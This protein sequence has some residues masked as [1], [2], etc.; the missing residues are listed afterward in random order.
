MIK[1]LAAAAAAALLLTAL[2]ATAGAGGSASPRFT[3]GADGIGDPYYPTAGNGG[4]DVAH[5]DLD[6]S[7]DPA[8]DL[9]RGTRRRSPPG[10][11]RTCRASTS[12]STV[13]PCAG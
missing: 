11:R 6:V 3:P 5:Y 13:S 9:L 1:S 12:T 4:Y 7:Y 8:T 2:P 10:R